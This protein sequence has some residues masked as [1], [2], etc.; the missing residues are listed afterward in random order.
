MSERGRVR[1]APEAVDLLLEMLEGP[2]PELS[3]AAARLTDGAAALLASGLLVRA[4]DEAVAVAD[5][6]HADA[7][8]SL[9]PAGAD[10]VVAYYSPAAGVV[11]VTAEELAVHQVDILRVLALL[12]KAFS[13]PRQSRPAE[14]AEGLVWEIGPAR[15][16]RRRARTAVW[17]A[18]RIWDD[19][20]LRA[21][22]EASHRRPHPEVRVLLT[23]APAGRVAQ[24]S[25]PGFEVVPIRNVLVAADTPIVDPAI[26]AARLGGPPPPKKAPEPI[27]LSPDGSRLTINGIVEFHFRQGEAREAIRKLVAARRAGRRLPIGDLAPHGS[28][29]RLFG[30][31][32]SALKRHV[33]AVDGLWGFGP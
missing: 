17:F 24:V 30:P 4:G 12:S 11:P 33:T 15:L 25:I 9:F 16:L 2:R 19:R 8:V 20:G 27:V 5:D 6:D 21:V 31:R 29:R 13:L 10:G 14:L 18:R 1:L 26:L 22:L 28:M 3:A 23:S 7:P 32:W